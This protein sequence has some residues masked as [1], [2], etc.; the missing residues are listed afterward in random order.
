[1]SLF[2]TGRSGFRGLNDLQ[3]F[4]RGFQIF[5]SISHRLEVFQNKLYELHREFLFLVLLHASFYI[6]S[7]LTVSLS[8]VSFCISFEGKKSFGQKIAQNK[9]HQ[10]YLIIVNLQCISK[11]QEHIKSLRTCLTTRQLY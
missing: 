5:S 9:N 3:T 10:K 1:M 6:G 7:A 11:N 4:I 2:F 8:K